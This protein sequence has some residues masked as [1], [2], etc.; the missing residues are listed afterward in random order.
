MSGNVVHVY[1]AIYMA[2]NSAS[3]IMLVDFGKVI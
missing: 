1:V 3:I 2:I